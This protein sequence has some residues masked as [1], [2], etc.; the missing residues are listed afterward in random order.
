MDTV[1]G[2]LHCRTGT[3]RNYLL[4]EAQSYIL[5]QVLAIE[6]HDY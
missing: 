4:K 1:L 3:S 6:R 5:S 2:S